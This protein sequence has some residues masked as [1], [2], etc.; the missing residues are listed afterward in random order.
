MEDMERRTIP[1]G[2]IL[3]LNG[4]PVRVCRQF[5]AES[6]PANWKSA[7]DS[8]ARNKQPVIT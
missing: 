8:R 7:N 2:T 5:I 1:G 3:H 6:S 4:M